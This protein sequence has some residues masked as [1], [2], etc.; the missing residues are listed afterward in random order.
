MA[1]AVA[2]VAID[3]D[4]PGHDV[5]GEHVVLQN[6]STRPVDLTGWTLRDVAPVRPH[7]FTFPSYS[8]PPGAH[9]RVWTKSGRVDP[10][11]LFWKRR[12]AVWNNPGDTAI[13]R[14]AEGTE[15][16]RFT[17]DDMVR[18][19][20][21][22]QRREPLASPPARFGASMAYDADR[23]NVVLVGG[24]SRATGFAD[25]WT[26][27]GF[28]WAERTPAESPPFVLYAHLA[29]DPVRH[30]VVLW[31]GIG[32][33]GAYLTDTWTW[34]GTDW[35]KQAPATSPPGRDAAMMEWDGSKIVLYGGVTDRVRRADMW[36]W[37][38]ETWTELAEAASPGV[39]AGAVTTFDEE[40]AQIVLQGGSSD[41]HTLGDTWTWDGEAWAH[42]QL[43]P[44][45][46]SRVSAAGAWD[47]SCVLVFGGVECATAPPPDGLWAW[48]GSGWTNVPDTGPVPRAL[49]PMARNA[50]GKG[51]VL[52]G[53]ADNVGA[54]DFGDTWTYR[55]A[56][57]A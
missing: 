48:D 37:D 32:H 20:S 34:D 19:L 50:G 36:A 54:G 35:T 9:M 5:A 31:G 52:F 2:I 27:D 24:G 39:R 17:Y 43:S 13:L 41:T 22:W 40:R 45:P 38:G 55:R 49:S 25:T 47:G 29:F 23:S 14:D 57:L 53:G 15:V 30:V 21:G 10:A 28:D 46:G 44:N 12:A 6:R 26:W 8:L 18:L 33:G 11:N 1:A 42:R 16:S 7:V 51:V 3:Y 4:P 56:A